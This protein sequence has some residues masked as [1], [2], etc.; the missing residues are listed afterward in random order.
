MPR[1]AIVLLGAGASYDC[2]PDINPPLDLRPEYKPPITQGLFENR[3]VVV[4]HLRDYDAA[5]QLASDLIIDIRNKKDLEATLRDISKSALPSRIAQV[6]QFGLYL[7]DLFWDISWTYTPEAVNYSRLANAL[8]DNYDKVAFV[9]LNYDLLLDRTLRVV[10]QGDRAGDLGS[11]TSSERWMLVKLH[12]SVNWG[13]RVIEFANT[14]TAND[15]PHI[16]RRR[17]IEI[18]STVSFEDNLGP[19]EI[20]MPERR[21]SSRGE[22]YYP[23]LSIPVEGKYEYN[24][25]EEHIRALE[26]VLQSATAVLSIGLSGKDADLLDLLHRNLPEVDRFHVIAGD[27]EA[28]GVAS[29]ISNHVPQL[30]SA[31]L[32]DN[33]FS[34]YVL[35]GGLE[36]FLAVAGR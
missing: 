36:S 22:L 32:F 7:Q 15:E 21:W 6:R 2:I 30:K 28:A 4:S 14:S 35:T 13:R 33:G 20:A 29:Q 1:T 24:C 9:T 17:Y 3:P 27:G 19:I 25:P 26:P 8:L 11:Y 18:V 12:G 10:N 16:L 5:M 23:A 34:G 31:S